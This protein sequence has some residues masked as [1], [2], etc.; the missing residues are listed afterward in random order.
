MIQDPLAIGAVLLGVICFSLFM[1]K[2]FKW[3][4]RLSVILWILFVG[5]LCSNT[6][7]IPTDAPL[8]GTLIDFTVP[9]AVC[10]ILLAVNLSDIR[11]AGT[12]MLVAFVLAS[13]GTALGV[14]IATVALN[15]PLTPIM[16]ED[17]WKLA[18]PYTGTYIG[19]SLNFF[20]LWTGLEIEDPDLLAAANAV[21]NITL[22]PLYA[23]W[24]FIPTLLVGKYVVAR[25]WN[26]QK[27]DTSAAARKERA[28]F[29]LLSIATLSFL[30]LTI[31]A[32]S[33]WV[34]QGLIEPILPGVP[35][36]LVITTFALLLA[37]VPQIRA[38][39]GAWEL[40]DLSFYLFFAAVG[41]LMD[42]YLAV[43]LSPILFAYVVIIMV[44]HLAI[45]Y[46]VGGLL[47]MDV[48]VLTI[49][50]VATKAGPAMVPPVAETKEWRHLVVPGIL[51]A[52]LGYAV[53]N[54][55]GFAV[56]QMVRW[57]M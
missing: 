52:L 25:H 41:A 31:M 19:G 39:K 42:F 43:I 3:A 36:I 30:A 23:F 16:G 26:P 5:A 11:K 18:G 24:M 22:F 54:Y 17:V 35:T 45:V 12:P 9:F 55:I 56:A 48:G 37:Q 40:G 51:I 20:S 13:V 57:I 14:V 7:L 49:A 27:T 47:R 38:L 28:P 8:Y 33:G 46:G 34:Q 21:D 29:S 44:V 50:S 1:V 32:V 10:V 4:E 15:G 53:G 2:H 6:G